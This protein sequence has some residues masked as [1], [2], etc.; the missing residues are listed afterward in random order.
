METKLACTFLC[1]FLLIGTAELKPKP[2]TEIIE[3]QSGEGTL[4]IAYCYVMN[5]VLFMIYFIRR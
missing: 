2:Q 3:I 5:V 4:E 1:L